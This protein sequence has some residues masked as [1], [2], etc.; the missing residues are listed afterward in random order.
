L[1]DPV[2]LALILA[3]GIIIIDFLSNYLFER[4]GFPDMLFLIILGI[5]IGP[6]TSLADTR[7]L[8]QVFCGFNSKSAGCC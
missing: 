3:G 1:T 7:E 6:V 8:N 2:T 5:L 4:T